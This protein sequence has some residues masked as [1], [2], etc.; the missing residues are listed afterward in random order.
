MGQEY[1]K[2]R[3]AN[4]PYTNPEN[5]ALGTLNGY[6]KQSRDRSEFDCTGIDYVQT[7]SGLYAD[8]DRHLIRRPVTIW[9]ADTAEITLIDIYDNTA[10]L[11]VDEFNRGGRFRIDECFTGS[12]LSDRPL[13]T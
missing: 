5:Y 9:N 13:P 1:P 11:T 3:I 2:C 10:T 12:E 6:L 7:I 4:A 8:R